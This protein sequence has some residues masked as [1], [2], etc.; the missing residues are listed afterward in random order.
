[1]A[2]GTADEVAA[3]A[4][5]FSDDGHWIDPVEDYSIAGTNPTLSTVEAWLDNISAQMDIAL[6]TNWFVTPV[7]SITQAQAYKAISQYVCGLVADMCY[8]ANG[9]ER[10][11]SPL[12]K[13]LQDLTKWVS[14]NADG[15]V[16]MGLTQ[17]PT[18]ST[19]NQASFR[20]VGGY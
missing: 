10:E 12:G 13:I 18:P 6:G 16:A 19:K 8:L 17:T 1:M 2:Y 5:A 20:I 9:V 15:L 11:V 3:L 7:N 14:Q 4:R